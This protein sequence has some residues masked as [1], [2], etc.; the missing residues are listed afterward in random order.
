MRPLPMG[1]EGPVFLPFLL[2]HSWVPETG[3][4]G[5]LRRIAAIFTVFSRFRFGRIIC[6]W[7][8]RNRPTIGK[9]ITARENS[10]LVQ[11]AFA[12]FFSQGIALPVLLARGRIAPLPRPTF[13]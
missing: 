9:V 5:S 12:A 8:S 7:T 11:V 1:Q 4:G 3:H 2:G 6:Q 13:P 10:A